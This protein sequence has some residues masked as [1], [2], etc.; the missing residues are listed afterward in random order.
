MR[1][2]AS[3]MMLP[4]SVRPVPTESVTERLFSMPCADPAEGHST[5]ARAATTIT[6][7]EG[8]KPD[9]VSK[10]TRRLSAQHGSPARRVGVS[11]SAALATL[12]ENSL[13]VPRHDESMADVTLP[14]ELPGREPNLYLSFPTSR[15]SR[16]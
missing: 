7:R 9:S 1:P 14:D 4:P 15:M 3:V 5:A 13:Y 10:N 16:P 11:A 2:T 8:D 12:H 6:E